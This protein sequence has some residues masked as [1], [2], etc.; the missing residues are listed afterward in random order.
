M[1]V[2]GRQNFSYMWNLRKSSNNVGKSRDLRQSSEVFRN[3]Q[4]TSYAFR[5]SLEIFG[6]LLVTSAIFR[7]PRITLGNLEYFRHLRCNWH[8]LYNLYSCYTFLHILLLHTWPILCLWLL[9]SIKLPDLKNARAKSCV[10]VGVFRS[11]I[12]IN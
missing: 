4:K 1:L 12:T 3:I 11:L 10:Y 8:P 5:R 6:S 2:W 9:I 7:I